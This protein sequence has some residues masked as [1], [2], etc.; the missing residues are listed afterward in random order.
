MVSVFGNSLL[1]ASEASILF[2]TTPIPTLQQLVNANKSITYFGTL[3]GLAEQMYPTSPF[4]YVSYFQP[5][6]ICRSYQAPVLPSGYNGD[7]YAD[8]LFLP[9]FYNGPST[10]G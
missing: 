1:N 8:D 9:G 2:P 5:F 6:P 4:N 10:T 7:F 3:G